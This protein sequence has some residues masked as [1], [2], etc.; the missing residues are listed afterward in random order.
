MGAPDEASGAYLKQDTNVTNLHN[1]YGEQGEGDGQ[2]APILGNT[3]EQFGPEEQ[4]MIVP[5]P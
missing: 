2:L 4:K 3:S 5:K 1:S